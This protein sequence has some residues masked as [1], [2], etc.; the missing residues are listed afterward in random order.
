MYFGSM[1][2]QT[3]DIKIVGTVDD[4]CFYRMEGGY[5]ARRKS[6]LTGKR[7]WKAKVFEGSR[8][9][10]GLMAKASPLASRLYRSLPK[11]QKGRDQFRALTG[12]IKLLLK[13]GWQENRIEAWF[14]ETLL[15]TKSK[16]S[17]KRTL[18]RQPLHLL[19]ALPTRMLPRLFVIPTNNFTPRQK[20]I[21]YP[22]G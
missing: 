12:K 9:S 15:P 6:S 13:A 14:V 16:A 19:I 1:A 18:K 20:P 5:Y 2:K 4:I 3:G 8:K 7:F 21:F 10:C 22:S 17:F 11:E